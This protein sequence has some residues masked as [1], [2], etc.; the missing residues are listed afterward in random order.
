MNMSITSRDCC[1]ETSSGYGEKVRESLSILS[2][3]AQFTHCHR[4]WQDLRCLNLHALCGT[5]LDDPS[6]ILCPVF[7]V[8]FPGRETRQPQRSRWLPLP[9]S[10][11]VMSQSAGESACEQF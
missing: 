7:A 6:L 8:L 4:E 5:P 2:P 3:P 10:F 11:L 1:L 9:P